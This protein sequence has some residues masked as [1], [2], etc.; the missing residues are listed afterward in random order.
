VTAGAVAVAGGWCLSSYLCVQQALLAQEPFV[1]L[2]LSTAADVRHA[3]ERRP[4]LCVGGILDAAARDAISPPRGPLT[5]LGASACAYRKDARGVY[6]DR[7]GD[8]YALVSLPPPD[9][10]HVV[11][12]EPAPEWIVAGSTVTA[13]TDTVGTVSILGT[14]D[15]R[16]TEVD[17]SVENGQDGGLWIGHRSATTYT[18][19]AFFAGAHI[20]ARVR[21]GD[22]P[23]VVP[24][25]SLGVIADPSFDL[26]VRE[27]EGKALVLYDQT[28]IGVLENPDLRGR[29]GLFHHTGGAHPQVFHDLR[30]GESVAPPP[31][32]EVPLGLSL[33]DLPDALARLSQ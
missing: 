16:P 26:R 9:D 5:L 1:R 31:V 18:A 30:V 28:V 21:A 19:I 32:V 24:F 23:P 13:R 27:V 11:S 17:L 8:T 15:V 4:D 33:G 10:L 14:D 7:V 22:D 12:L 3:M 25:Q 2:A 29:V 6:L 20:E